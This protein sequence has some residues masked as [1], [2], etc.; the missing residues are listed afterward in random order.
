MEVP[1]NTFI[2]WKSH[3]S[4]MNESPIGF[5]WDSHACPMEVSWDSMESQRSPMEVPGE[6]RGNSMEVPWT[7]RGS[8]MNG[9]WN[10]CESLLRGP[11]GYNGGI[12][13]LNSRESPTGGQW[14]H[15]GC[16]TNPMGFP[17]KHHGS[18]LRVQWESHENPMEANGGTMDVP[19]TLT[20]WIFHGGPRKYRT[21]LPQR[22]RVTSVI[23]PWDSYEV[24]D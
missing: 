19:L 13:S 14:G 22:F 4:P 15:L 6:S 16:T 20:L 11:W 5:P 17:R 21:G 8:T 7:Y 10:S 23:L 24:E 3:G 2:T 18:P 1:W 12:A 9:P